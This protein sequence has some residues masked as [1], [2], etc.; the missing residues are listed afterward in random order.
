MLANS[1]GA[2]LNLNS[3]ALPIGSLA[4]GG[5]AGGN[6]LASALLTVGGDNNSPG[7]LRGAISGAG[8]LLKVGLGTLTLTGTNTCD[9]SLV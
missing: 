6:V 2:S 9:E 4:G 5:S 7:A 1:A 3:L 8:G